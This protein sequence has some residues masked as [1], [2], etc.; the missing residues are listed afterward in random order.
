LLR[1]SPARPDGDPPRLL[2]I[3]ATLR[4]RGIECNAP[5]RY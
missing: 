5:G 3:G 1:L 2:A 4:L